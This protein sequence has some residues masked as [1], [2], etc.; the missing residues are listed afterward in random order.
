MRHAKTYYTK[1]GRPTSTLAG[2]KRAIDPLGRLYG[3]TPVTE[4]GP[5]R[6]KALR[7]KLLE[8]G[9]TNRTTINKRIGIIK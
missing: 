1:D 7:H 9:R 3:R 5:K 4:F 6:L 2:I 8:D